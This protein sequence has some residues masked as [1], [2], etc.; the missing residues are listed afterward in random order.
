MSVM[1]LLYA[2]RRRASIAQSQQ[3]KVAYHGTSA[4][5][6][7]AIRAVGLLPKTGENTLDAEGRDAEAKICLTSN[8]KLAK[9]YAGPG[10]VVLAVDLDHPEV[11]SHAP[12]DDEFTSNSITTNQ[13][14]PPHVITVKERQSRG[15]R[16]AQISDAYAAE[17]KLKANVSQV[18][19]ALIN[20]LATEY[21]FREAHR[22]D[23]QFGSVVRYFHKN[24]DQLVTTQLPVAHGGNSKWEYH[25]RDGVKSTGLD[26]PSLQNH[27][28]VISRGK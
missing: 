3:E 18:T 25:S 26:V 10:G 20:D 2:R 5:N 24:G 17:L 12:K 23:N 21:G 13:R 7:K 27:L 28:K 22:L 6:F 19:E 9:R 11:S 8:P 14:I 1:D 4:A 15:L 16:L